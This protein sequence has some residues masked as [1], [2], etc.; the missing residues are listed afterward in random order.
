MNAVDKM[1]PVT[2]ANR[3]ELLKEIGVRKKDLA[4][5]DRTQVRTIAEEV[6]VAYFLPLFCGEKAHTVEEVR[7]LL[8]NWITVA[9][10]TWSDVNV[11]NTKGQVVVSV[12]GVCDASIFKPIV[13]RQVST[14]YTMH[15]AQT[16]MAIHHTL[17]DRMIQ[18]DLTKKIGV[19]TAGATTQEST[20]RW[21][22]VFAHYGKPLIGGQS[23]SGVNRAEEES[24]YEW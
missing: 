17:G 7:H 8:S 19:M 11:V 14:S 21:N 16:K 5:M 15:L 22:L 12:P 6:F 24:E 9:G 18:E 4:R 13:D 20:R 2:L 3:N 23:I 10:T 1:D